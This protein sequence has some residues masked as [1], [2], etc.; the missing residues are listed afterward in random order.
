MI[1]LVGQIYHLMT[2]LEDI[3][4]LDNINMLIR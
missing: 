2:T 3:D 4:V 1:Y